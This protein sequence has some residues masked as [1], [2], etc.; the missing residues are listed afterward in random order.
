MNSSCDCNDED[1]STSSKIKYY[2]WCIIKK[3]L[4]CI[5]IYY[6]EKLLYRIL[7]YLFH[8]SFLSIPIQI[9]LHLLLLRYL[10][11][12]VAF[13]GL[14][15]F[16]SRNI[17]YKRGIIQASYILKELNILKSSFSLLFD[18]LKP[19]EEIK[20]FFILQRNIKNSILIIK[21]IWHI[22]YKMKEKFNS[23]TSDQNIFFNNI[24]NLKLTLENSKILNFLSDVIKKIKEEKVCD[25]KYISK[26]G[27]NDIIERKNSIKKLMDTNANDIINNLINQL[28]DYIGEDYSAYS[29]RY[30]RNYF[31][32]F[33]FASL[34]QFDV[35]L[36]SHFIFEQKI[37]ITKDKTAKLDYI[38]I[39]SKLS[40]KQAQKKLMIICGPNAEPYQIF[41]RNIPLSIYL[42]KGIDILC[43]NYRGYGYSTGKADFNN[44][45]EDIIEIY[46]EIKNN[47]NY[48]KIGVHGISLG[49]IP[50]C[51][52]AGE[53]KDI[54][55]LVS[56][57]NFGQIENIAK[58]CF[59]GKYLVLLY[60]LLL[61]PSSRN[62]ENYLNAKCEKIILNDPCDE[63][64][65]EEGSLK[66]MI[67][68]KLCSKYIYLEQNLNNEMIEM[69]NINTLETID[70]S[71]NTNI[72]DDNQIDI[73]DEEDNKILKNKSQSNY[74][75]INQSNQSNGTDDKNLLTKG[76]NLTML[77]IL[78]SSDKQTFISNIIKIA[79]FLNSFNDKET[80][81][82][83][84]MEYINTQIFEIFTNIKS[85]GDTLYRITKIND[86]RYNQ[87]LFIENFFNNLFI[88]G[89]YDKLDDYGSI[90]NSTEF[91]ENMLEKNINLIKSFLNSENLINFKN[92]EIITYINIFYD[93]LIVIK[94]RINSILIKIDNKFIPLKEGEKYE[95]EL[96]KLGKGYLVSLNC[97]HNG[98]LSDEEDIVFKFYL[99]KSELF[100]SDKKRNEYDNDNYIFNEE[101]NEIE[102]L[103]NSFSGLTNS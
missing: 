88:W 15:F 48:E 101:N 6:M 36:S 71:I 95:N 47:N 81:Q 89:T 18:E 31:S 46:N 21:K 73:E 28:T 76:R 54:K 96:I 64:V 97:G 19:V 1:I 33:L 90:Y 34:N 70:T 2:S 45:K 98:L 99:N 59:L 4:I 35:E 85:A 84:I 41:A 91:I 80:S 39:K 60:K 7:T 61:I 8:F 75:L 62:V 58:S 57:R 44:L 11:L 23:L 100:F 86:N 65:T 10:V 53:E 56:D 77:D 40:M 51:Y 82:Q 72:S 92:L 87:N 22:F 103:D 38:I 29:P 78:L 32:N 13:A 55:L 24:S 42:N 37:L 83:S 12:K 102:D 94:K 69:K 74:N 49:G 3:I 17:Q 68:E 27:R 66:T 5:F 25:I 79:K 50:A 9:I 14:S 20:Y 52:L 67:S 93:F 43:W 26:E 63:I 16:I 30:I